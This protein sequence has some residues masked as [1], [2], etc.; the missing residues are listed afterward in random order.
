MH[1]RNL[2]FTGAALVVVLV[3][4][5]ITYN[6][7]QSPAAALTAPNY[8]KAKS[9]PSVGACL[10]ANKAITL[11]AN[12]RD[13]VEIG[14]ISHLV[15]VPAGTHVDVQVATYSN[16]KVTG[17]D[18]YPDKFGSY[19]FILSKQGYGWTVTQFQRCES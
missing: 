15:D 2:L 5:F 16:D 10:T 6:L 9:A 3:V 13:K 1:K 8:A 7:K 18:R 17:S 14:A 19:N 12:E 4:G 11:P